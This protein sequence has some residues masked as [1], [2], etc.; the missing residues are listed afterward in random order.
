MALQASLR[1]LDMSTQR[2]PVI[3]STSNGS[4]M[5]TLYLRGP[6]DSVCGASIQFIVLR[7]TGNAFWG[8]WQSCQPQPVLQSLHVRCRLFVDGSSRLC[9]H[10][11]LV[12][13]SKNALQFSLA[14]FCSMQNLSSIDIGYNVRG[15]NPIPSCFS[16]L[17]KL[18]E[19][20]MDRM[21]IVGDVP[22]ALA[23]LPLQYVS[24]FGN[25]ITGGMPVFASIPSLRYLNV[26]CN[27]FT[28]AP[29]GMYHAPQA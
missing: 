15:S 17:S 8:D 7:L 1:S 28:P 16:S 26:S 23:M 11:L 4:N 20:A 24:L 13:V 18:T 29:I 27:P 25:L 19:L 14:Q 22:A 10:G 5:L 6:I 3:N 2:R 12:Q 21:G 9:L